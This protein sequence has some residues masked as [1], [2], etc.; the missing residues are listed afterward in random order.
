[1][2]NVP[3]G[4]YILSAKVV[5]ATKVENGNELTESEIRCYLR[6]QGDVDEAGAHLDVYGH[7]GDH[8]TLPLTVSHTFASTGTVTLTCKDMLAYMPYVSE[9]R[10]K[11]WRFTRFAHTAGRGR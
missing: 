6:A 9:Q 4:N 2:P 1:M 11:G 5:A 10:S 3:A 8:A 7:P